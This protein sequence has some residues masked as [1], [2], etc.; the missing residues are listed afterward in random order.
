MT[1]ANPPAAS[2]YMSAER[3]IGMPTE[4]MGVCE[5]MLAEHPFG[6]V[7]IATDQACV[8]CHQ[9]GTAFRGFLPRAW[10]HPVASD[11]TTRRAA[12]GVLITSGTRC[13]QVDRLGGSGDGIPG[14]CRD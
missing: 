4:A 6:A 5:P 3:R 7:P 11:G 13:F 1:L 2:G 9:H 8:A 14:G 12:F 10:D